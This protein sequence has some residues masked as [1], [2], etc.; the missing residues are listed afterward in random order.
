MTK[1][2]LATSAFN[3]VKNDFDIEDAIKNWSHFVDE[4]VIATIPSEDN[5]EELLDQVKDQSEI[6]IKI[7]KL[8]DST[9]VIGWD[10]RIKNAAHQAAT[11]DIVVQVDLDER[12]GGRTELWRDIAKNLLASKDRIKS[13]MIPSINLFGGYYTYSDISKKWYMC[14]KDGVQRGVVNFA[15]TEEGFDRT[16]SD[17]TEAIDEDGNL[18]PSSDIVQCTGSWSNLEYCKKRMPFIWHLGYLSLSRRTKLNKEFWKEKWDS[19]GEGESDVIVDI[20]SF[21][22][23]EVFEHKLEI[24]F[25]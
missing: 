13:L 23:K 2:S 21:E 19:Y 8:D 12:M 6:K 22:K 1:I 14:V 17:S 20:E 5:T 18:V 4:I 9:D 3:I 25:L 16:K 10:G 11:H 15:K 24:D 7:V